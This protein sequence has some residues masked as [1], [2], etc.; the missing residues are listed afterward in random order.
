MARVN[1]FTVEAFQN[2]FGETVLPG[3]QV[4]FIT[5]STGRVGVRRGKYRGKY[6]DRNGKLAGTSVEYPQKLNFIY[7]RKT[8]V[9]TNW[10]KAWQA[11][12]ATQRHQDLKE[13]VIKNHNGPAPQE[14]TDWRGNKTTFTPYDYELSRKL[15][16]VHRKVFDELYETRE[17]TVNRKTV[18]Q[19]NRLYKTDARVIE[20]LQQ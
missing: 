5:C 20:D 15:D 18:L 4:I 1:T 7:D 14:R 16:E 10:Y 8:A 17:E 6:I 9:R 13:E 3:D 19:M 11:A 2:S 12:E